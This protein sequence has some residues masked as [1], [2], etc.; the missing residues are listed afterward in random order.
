[1]L[2]AAE[3]T[4]S[5]KAPTH[6]R[7]RPLS[8]RSIPSALCKS[9]VDLPKR[10]LITSHHC[11]ADFLQWQHSSAEHRCLFS[12]DCYLHGQ[13]ERGTALPHPPNAA[14][15]TD[16]ERV[17]GLQLTSHYSLIPL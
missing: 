7:Q 10:L 4:R 2:P 5:R 17:A 16:K 1:M 13:E 3:V 9:I 6:Y 8:R 12:A 15:L 11:C 14:S